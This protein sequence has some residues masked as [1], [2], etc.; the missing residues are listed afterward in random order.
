MF[1]KIVIHYLVLKIVL[2]QFDGNFWWM[3]KDLNK[4]HIEPPPPQFEELS[5][6]DTDESAKI[7]FRDKDYSFSF[8]DLVIP[9]PGKSNKEEKALKSDK[10][11]F[12][13]QF[14]DKSVITFPDHMQQDNYLV[15]KDKKSTI[16]ANNNNKTTKTSEDVLDFKFPDDNEFWHTING[17]KTTRT[18]STTTEK[19]V[20]NNKKNTTIL[21]K[22]KTPMQ[23]YKENSET[24][25][26]CTS[27]KKI[28]CNRRGGAVYAKEDR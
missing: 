5:E 6:F 9:R 19:S 10:M 13:I 20:T 21:I 11:K 2:A 27:M 12:D 22:N 26:I 17:D 8:S 18:S 4:Y 1:V 23:V 28:E 25:H 3:N 16:K 24:E 14:Q 7:V 15:E